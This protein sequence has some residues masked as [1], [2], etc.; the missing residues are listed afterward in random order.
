MS[1]FFADPQPVHT[2]VESCAANSK[3]ARGLGHV[4]ARPCQ[5]PQDHTPFRSVKAK[6]GFAG[7]IS[8]RLG[9]ERAAF[10]QPKRAAYCA[11]R[12]D[13]NII[14]VDRKEL[15]AMCLIPRNHNPGRAEVI[16]EQVGLDQTGQPGDHRKNQLVEVLGLI[17]P[18]GGHVQSP[19]KRTIGAENWRVDA[20]HADIVRFEMLVA[21]DY[22]CAGLGDAGADAV[23]ALNRLAPVLTS[24]KPPTAKGIRLCV[25]GTAC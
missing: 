2:P 23:C 6:R 22:Q 17:G 21:M 1:G 7:E 13:H 3:V 20:A 12:P 8:Q 14:A 9:I 16:A 4:P 19:G 10:G 5:S 25:M 24:L 11:G 18:G 15:C